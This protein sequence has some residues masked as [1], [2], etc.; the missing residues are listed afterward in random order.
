[1]GAMSRVIDE[2]GRIFGKVNIIDLLVLLVIVAVVVL[3]AVRFKDATVD[4]V[5]VRIVFT[6][7]RAR[8]ATVNALDVGGTVTD[9]GGTVFGEVQD[10]SISP[11]VE[12]YLTQDDELKAFDSPIFSDVS[13]EVLG[14]GVVSGSS[15][16]VG[17]VPIRVGK[18]LVL[19]GSG[20]EIATTITSVAWGEEAVQ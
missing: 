6:L 10:I 3:A 15:V 17:S 5:P 16:R 11:T 8:D 20:F 9:D 14:R 13:I 12:Q 19:L 7:E 18:R 2:R 4:T 1:M